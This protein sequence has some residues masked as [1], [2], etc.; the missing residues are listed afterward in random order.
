MY[1]II[2]IEGNGAG[3]REESIIDIA[4]FKF[5]G[6]Q[7]MD[8][9]FSLVNPEAE[10][11]PYVQKLTGISTKMVR[12]APKFHELARRIVEITEGT[13]L[14]GHNIDFDYR[15]LRQEFRRL[16]YDFHIETLDTIPLA[17]QLIPD[18]EGY[19]LGK[20]VKSLGIPL[21]NA[22]RAE[23]DARATLELFKILISKDVENTI[24]QKLHEDTNAKT[25]LNKVKQLTQDL[26]SKVGI[27]YLQNKKGEILYSEYVKNINR[28]VKKI[29]NAKS[30]RMMP[31]QESTSQVQ[32]ELVGNALLAQIIL[33]QKQLFRE[34][35]RPI[36]LYEID[37]EWKLKSRAS[38]GKDIKPLLEFY[39]TSQGMK[40][41]RYIHQSHWKED[42]ATLGNIFSLSEN[43]KIFT[44]E[45]RR[46]GEK[47]FIVLEKSGVAGYGFYEFHTQI[48]T[49]KKISQLMIP[50]HIPMKAIE[51]ELKL[52]YLQGEMKECVINMP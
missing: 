34:K 50:I 2:D 27:F 32:Y 8:Q 7:I 44:I 10:I 33:T 3:Y 26:P 9:F 40:A 39:S 12:T 14:V 22:H 18:A 29:F 20:L 38:M 42:I 1:T 24:I 35:K 41:L 23:N 43:R 36:G 25:Y 17:K 37:E 6:H 49:W 21:S 30:K 13:T 11:A 47:A 48:S 15:M 46:L 19:S 31:I 5:D 52:A 51:N 4:I 45:G 28:G 16:G